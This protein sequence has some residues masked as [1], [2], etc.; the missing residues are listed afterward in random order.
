MTEPAAEQEPLDPQLDELH[1]LLQRIGVPVG[2]WPLIDRI[3]HELDLGGFRTLGGCVRASRPTKGMD[4]R[5]FRGNTTGLTETEAHS[6]TDPGDT[7][8]AISP[9]A[10]TNPERPVIWCVDHPVQPAPTAEELARRAAAEERAAAEAEKA[11]PP[12]RST[13]RPRRSPRIIQ[14]R[15]GTQG[16]QAP[17]SKAAQPRHP[18]ARR[19]TA[20]HLHRLLHRKIRDRRVPLLDR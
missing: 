16:R 7:L 3:V 6:F 20:H 18:R 19:R 14:A 11:Q 15:Q 17:R 4:V 9:R 10:W 5:F 13:P 12:A 2:N 1:T 8:G